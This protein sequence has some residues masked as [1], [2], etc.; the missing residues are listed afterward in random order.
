MKL[1]TKFI[2]GSWTNDDVDL[3]PTIKLRTGSKVNPD[4]QLKV[5]ATSLAICWLRWGFMVSFGK[6]INL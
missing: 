5:T 3:L 1:K 2:T 4:T 6:V